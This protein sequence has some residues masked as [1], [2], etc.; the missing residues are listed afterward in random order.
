MPEQQHRPYRK[1]PVADVL[2]AIKAHH[3]NV[4]AIAEQFDVQRNYV[5]T[6]IRSKPTLLQAFTDE[7]EA[8]KDL[9][10]RNIREDLEARD[11]R[12]TA[13][14][15]TFLARDRGWALPKASSPF[16]DGD[17]H[18]NEVNIQ[19]VNIQSFEPGSFAPRGTAPVSLNALPPPPETED[20]EGIIIEGSLATEVE[21]QGDDEALD[22]DED[23]M[24]QEKTPSQTPAPLT[25]AEAEAEYRA[26]REQ[27]EDDFRAAHLAKV[28][29]AAPE[30][31]HLREFLNKFDPAPKPEPEPELRT[32]S[33]GGV[34]QSPPEEDD[35]GVIAPRR[36]ERLP[37]S[38]GEALGAPR[39]TWDK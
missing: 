6:K 33:R 9:A 24:P 14:V 15:L 19:A 4:S 38:P 31:A 12:A 27:A 35:P 3:G 16:A 17:S 1:L 32:F 39:W 8:L 36:K 23:P 21:A 11:W 2:A 10:E 18:V 29:E 5:Y 22:D 13:F 26:A 25:T 30:A 34:R 37:R 20:S 28:A 7:R